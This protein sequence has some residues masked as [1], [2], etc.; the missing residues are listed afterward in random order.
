MVTKYG[1]SDLIGPIALEAGSSKAMFGSNVG[2]KEYS[3][4]V[5]ATID[6]EVSKIMK[7]AYDRAF[8]IITE[9]RPALDAISKALVAAETLKRAEFEQILIAHGITPKKKERIEDEA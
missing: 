5:G 4:S 9:N 2:D 8:K 1:M 3:E 6:G 7:E